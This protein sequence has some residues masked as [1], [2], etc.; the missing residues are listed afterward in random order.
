MVEMFLKTRGAQEKQ[1]LGVQKARR[2]S[3]GESRHRKR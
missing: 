1:L 2:T 3:G